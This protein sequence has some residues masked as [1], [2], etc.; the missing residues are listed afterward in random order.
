MVSICSN[1]SFAQRSHLFAQKS[2]HIRKTKEEES[3]GILRR[4][5]KARNCIFCITDI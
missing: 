1:K 3:V 5:E 2:H 4:D